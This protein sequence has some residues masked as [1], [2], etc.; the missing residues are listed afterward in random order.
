MD[1]LV[2]TVTATSSKIVSDIC[3]KNIYGKYDLVITDEL[4]YKNI[5][6]MYISVDSSDGFNDI[7][8]GRRYGIYSD[9]KEIYT[10]ILSNG[11]IFPINNIPLDKVITSFLVIVIY[12]LP[13]RFVKSDSLVELSIIES[14][15]YDSR[16]NI[17]GYKEMPPFNTCA[18]KKHMLVIL[19]GI[20]SILNKAYFIDE[21]YNNIESVHGDN[22]KYKKISHLDNNFEFVDDYEYYC[23]E[24][25]DEYALGE[26]IKSTNY[27]HDFIAEMLKVP[28]K[29]ENIDGKTTGRYTIYSGCDCLGAMYIL[30][31]KN[32][33]SINISLSEKMIQ[34]HYV[35]DI[36]AE[37][38]TFAYGKRITTF[39]DINQLCVM[40]KNIDITINFDECI[41]DETVYIAM[42]RC[43]LSE[44][45]RICVANIDK[46]LHQLVN[47]DNIKQIQP[48]KMS[49]KLY[50]G[51]S[52]H[53]LTPYSFIKSGKSY[54]ECSNHALTPDSLPDLIS[55]ESDADSIASGSYEEIVENTDNTGIAENTGDTENTGITENTGDTENTG[56]TENTGDK[57]DTE[58]TGNTENTGIKGIQR[59]QRIQR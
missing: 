54:I 55:I 4:L 23:N 5:Y 35:H 12:N 8:I 18:N 3:K 48:I 34:P 25:C 43:Y 13:E 47:I 16:F 30:S 45:I 39:D 15:I 56:N 41:G 2:N 19:S 26:L 50:T 20:C 6:E 17:N 52:G 10:S 31:D 58:N 59:I 53:A 36:A 27:W 24:Y 33:N 29:C 32:I 7:L 14:T 21:H 46:S 28:L 40:F 49:G 57:G 9:G 22:C 38:E 51:Y 11:N 44:N 37:F 1:Q 42:T